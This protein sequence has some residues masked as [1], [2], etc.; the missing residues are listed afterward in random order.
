VDDVIV[1]A[2]TSLTAL[3]PRFG[4]IVYVDDPPTPLDATS[5]LARHP[6]L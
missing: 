5:F 6:D 3:E 2:P 1:V 4:P